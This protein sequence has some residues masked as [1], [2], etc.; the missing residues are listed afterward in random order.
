MD[1]NIRLEIAP[2]V[3]MV[4][5]I[6]ALLLFNNPN[7]T[8]ISATGT[9]SEVAKNVEKAEKKADEATKGPDIKKTKVHIIEGGYPE[10]G[11]TVPTEENKPVKIEGNSNAGR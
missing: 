7:P 8:I 10:E 6:N 3:E 2:S 1:I 5:L 9:K 11:G 4:T